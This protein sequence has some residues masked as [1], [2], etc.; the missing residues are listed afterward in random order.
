MPEQVY[1][2]SVYFTGHV[3]GV[4]FRWTTEGIARRFEV[5][6]Q[7]MNLADGRVHLEAEGGKA[8]VDSFLRQIKDR[9]KGNIDSLEK[10]EAWGEPK[11]RE[12]GIG[13]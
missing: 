4:G 1:K 7:V 13:Y 3:Q 2:V 10:T 12:F 11:Y 5:T 8:E 6:G 9:M